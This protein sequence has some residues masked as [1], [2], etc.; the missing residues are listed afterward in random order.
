[1]NQTILAALV[2]SAELILHWISLYVIY[3]YSSWEQ[4][5]AL[6]N[7]AASSFDIEENQSKSS[8]YPP[9]G[10]VRM[11]KF[12]TNRQ[13]AVFRTIFV[14][15]VAASVVTDWTIFLFLGVAVLLFERHR[16][17]KKR[18]RLPDLQLRVYIFT[19]LALFALLVTTMAMLLWSFRSFFGVIQEDQGKRHRIVSIVGGLAFLVLGIVVASVC[20]AAHGPS[21]MVSDLD[22]DDNSNPENVS[23]FVAMG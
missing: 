23:S 1:M 13:S 10:E 14:W 2:L 16:S 8:D 22:D 6:L 9:D 3:K 7:S 19:M 20:S 11:G 18:G 15:L 5:Q 21:R 12:F 17:T 4:E